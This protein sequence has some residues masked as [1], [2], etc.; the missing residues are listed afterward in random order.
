[1]WFPLFE[2]LKFQNYNLSYRK[3][4]TLSIIQHK[5]QISYA[6]LQSLLHSKN[7]TSNSAWRQILIPRI[8]KKQSHMETGIYKDQLPRQTEVH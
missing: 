4:N 2:D 8:L 1:M 6:K 5:I 3:E 7:L